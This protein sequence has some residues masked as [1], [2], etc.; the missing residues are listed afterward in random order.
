MV[1][2]FPDVPDQVSVQYAMPSDAAIMDH[3][4]N[5]YTLARQG[6]AQRWDQISHKCGIHAVVKMESYVIIVLYLL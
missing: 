3:L 5:D 6:S 1:S 4:R 2:L